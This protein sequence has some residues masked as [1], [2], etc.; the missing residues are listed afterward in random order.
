MNTLI[1]TEAKVGLGNYHRR[2]K[3]LVCVAKKGRETGLGLGKG[4]KDIYP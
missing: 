2:L 4:K 1:P 3:Q